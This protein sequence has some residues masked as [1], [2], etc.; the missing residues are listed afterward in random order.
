MRDSYTNRNHCLS[1]EMCGRSSGVLLY[2]VFIVCAL[3]SE[4]PTWLTYFLR[5]FTPNSL[6]CVWKD[7]DVCV[8]VD[9][10][11]ISSCFMYTY[12]CSIPSGIALLFERVS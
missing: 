3:P 11:F 2:S 6:F 4:V 8:C 7:L 10:A 9:A 12:L 5:L 1:H